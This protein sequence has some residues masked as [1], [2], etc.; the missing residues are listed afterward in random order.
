MKDKIGIIPNSIEGTKLG[1]HSNNR[2]NESR[3]W[4]AE[5][6]DSIIDARRSRA[7]DAEPV[8]VAY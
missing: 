3:S 5:S 6:I 2:I 1:K 8:S 7:F 4:K